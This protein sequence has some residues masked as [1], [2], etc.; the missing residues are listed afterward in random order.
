MNVLMI[1]SL[2]GNDYSLSLCSGL[3][4][5]GTDIQLMVT[6]D[7]VVETAVSFPIRHFAPAKNAKQGRLKKTWLYILYLIKLPV[8]IF[9][10]KIDVI[11]FQFL[12]RERMESVYLPLLRLLGIK[13]AY[14]AHNVLPHEKSRLDYFFKSL[15]YKS[16]HSIIVH[17][18][19]IK[20]KLAANFTINAD[21]IKIVPHGNFDIYLSATPPTKKNARKQLNLPQNSKVLLFFGNIREYKGLDTLLAAFQQSAVND[22]QLH[23]LIAG[24]PRNE[25]LKRKYQT[26]INESGVQDKIIFHPQFIPTDEVETY[27][28]AADIVVLPYK[29][30]DH[31]GI[32][33]LAYSFGKPII[34]TRV[35]DIETMIAEDGTGLLLKKNTP[36]DLAETI[37]HAFEINEELK[38]MG[39]IAQKLNGTKYSWSAIAKQTNLVYAGIE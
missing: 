5:A 30:I 36:E 10:N 21:K 23:L 39:K 18:T 12:R 3:H 11:H 38:A 27:F 14:T 6:E 4:E 8:F 31:S 22:E 34:A 20:Q 17:S 37:N 7:R 32:V 26:L 25:A 1:D 9:K 16:A 29:N 33:H 2:V 13:I 28:M 24:S 35:G 15:I 19:Y